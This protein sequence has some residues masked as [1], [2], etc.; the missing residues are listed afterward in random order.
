MRRASTGQGKLSLLRR[1]VLRV[2][3]VLMKR[4]ANITVGKAIMTTRK[5]CDGRKADN[6][7]CRCCE[8]RYLQI[9]R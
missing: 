9:S 6:G 1:N 8:E 2:V 5:A 7:I 3:H 4:K